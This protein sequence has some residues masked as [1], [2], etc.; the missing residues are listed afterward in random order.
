[1]SVEIL[2]YFLAMFPHSGPINVRI[3]ADYRNRAEES[4]VFPKFRSPTKYGKHK[5]SLNHREENSKPLDSLG[6]DVILKFHHI[7]AQP[8]N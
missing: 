2:P 5:L 7:M 6:P 8:T 4:G 1:M 3:R